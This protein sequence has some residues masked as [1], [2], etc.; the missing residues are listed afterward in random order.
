M[1]G[2]TIAVSPH[3]RYFEPWA[4]A[5]GKGNFM[6]AFW[7][8][9]VYV[10]FA[11]TAI[12]VI[13]NG[14]RQ[15]FG[16]FLVP[17]STDLGWGRGEFALAIAI[18]NLVMGCAAPFVAALGDRLG[19]IRVIALAGLTYGLG[20]LLMSMSVTPE[21][22]VLSAGLVVGLGAAGIGLTLPLA[23]VGRVAPDSSR[24]LWLGI[25]TAG[26]SAGQFLF[27]PTSSGLIG[28]YGWADG[29]FYLSMIIAFTIP[30][31][32]SL[33]AGSAETLARPDTL[34]LGDALKQASGH[35]G[36]WL[37]VIGFFVCGAQ[38]Q[39]IGTH[40]PGFL[41]DANAEPWL[42]AWA[43]GTIGLFNMVGTI[44]AGWMGQRW[45]KK[46][47]L[48]LLYLSRGLLFFVFIL[49]PVNVYTVLG[50]SAVLGL[51]WLSTVPL[52]S[53]IVAQ[54]FGPRYM[55]TL[56]A[57][58]F[59]SHQL[60]AFTGVWLGGYVYDKYGSYNAAWWF[61]IALGAIASLIHFAI[62]DRPAAAPQPAG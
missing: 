36:Y 47:L 14:S 4:Q 30:L 37:L 35:R 51:L 21:S 3:R 48:S 17:M 60:G 23:L 44:A 41:K 38:V 55:G 58:V 18:Q 6:K 22:M 12:I 43:L 34:T 49:L 7:R 61:I 11:A 13:T 26:G 20:V 1:R 33:K 2:S 31:A 9:P 8:T 62:D 53:G 15:S 40:L 32:L 42:A 54:V 29:F 16:L 5:R 52:T 27:A 45:R 46:N 56:F 39:Y 24:S 59:F 28:T 50:F 10:L 57:I 25:V 19:P